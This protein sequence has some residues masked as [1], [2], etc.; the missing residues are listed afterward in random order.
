MEP[1]LKFRGEPLRAPVG[2]S[3]ARQERGLEEEHAGGPDGGRST[4]KGQNQAAHHRLDRKEQE[5]AAKDCGA[6]E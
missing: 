2:V 3:V 6:M 5:G 1:A 4:K